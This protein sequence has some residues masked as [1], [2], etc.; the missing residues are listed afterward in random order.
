MILQPANENNKMVLQLWADR[1]DS[2]LTKLP[3][4][5]YN[6]K[7]F[8]LSE[9][10]KEPWTWGF[11]VIT[12]EGL[13]YYENYKR[14]WEVKDTLTFNK[15]VNSSVFVV[16]HNPMTGFGVV[17]LSFYKDKWI[18]PW[19]FSHEIR[20]LMASCILVKELTKES[21]LLV[22]EFSSIPPS[23]DAP[24]TLAVFQPRTIDG[25][26]HFIYCQRKPATT[27]P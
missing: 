7:C 23:P 22:S 6:P 24:R 27:K 10:P 13:L 11:L 16:T 17:D 9:T 20:L 2:R 26:V 5:K 15:D 21:N 18:N 12:N 14:W 3:Q 19:W 1:L 25:P 4:D 8:Y